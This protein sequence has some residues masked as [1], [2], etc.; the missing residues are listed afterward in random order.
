MD[1]T[2][3][4]K[5]AGYPNVRDATGG[6]TRRGSNAPRTPAPPRCVV[7]R[8]ARDVDGCAPASAPGTT[9]TVSS[10]SDG[11]N[12]HDEFKFV[13]F[14]LPIPGRPTSFDPSILLQLQPFSDDERAKIKPAVGKSKRATASG[15]TAAP[16]AALETRAPATTRP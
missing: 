11:P 6:K 8:R 5:H 9:D 16:R 12:R 7:G 1:E 13:K 2:W 3:G 4:A 15:R 10:P 14:Q